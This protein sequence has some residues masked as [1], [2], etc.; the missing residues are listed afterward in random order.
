MEESLRKLLQ[1]IELLNSK[2][3]GQ[4]RDVIA[5]GPFLALIDP[6]TDLTWLNY[7]VP[8]ELLDGLNLAE[9]LSELREVFQERDRTLRFEFTEFLWPS[10]PQALEEAGLLLEVRHP[11]LLCTP[12]DFQPYQAPAV[13]VQMLTATDD[14][15]TLTTFLSIRNQG[16]EQEFAEEPPTDKEISQ[17]RE[18]LQT[19]TMRYGLAHLDGT[20]AGV[21]MTTPMSGICEL[22]GVTTLSAMRRRGVAATLSSFLVKDH[23][24][25]GGDLVWLSAGD[26][27]AQAT[28]ERIGFQKVASRL[29]Y[30]DVT[31]KEA[32]YC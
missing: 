11:M 20:P 27:I 12:S 15:K 25:G 19:G 23:F 10:L 30:I 18:Q 6:S 8:V 17:L 14:T 22:V 29:N 16:F 4:N 9:L 2:V 31:F 3:A 7:A 26:K 1:R 24:R 13:T 5:V 28:Y 21:A 32:Q